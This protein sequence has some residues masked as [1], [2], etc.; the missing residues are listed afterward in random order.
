[1]LMESDCLP[2]CSR[3][4]ASVLGDSH[5]IRRA[6]WRPGLVSVLGRPVP[7]SECQHSDVRG[8]E[9]RWAYL[10]NSASLWVWSHG[11]PRVSAEVGALVLTPARCT[12]PGAGGD[13]SDGLPGNYSSSPSST[14]WGG[15]QVYLVNWLLV[16]WVQGPHLSGILQGFMMG[17]FGRADFS[18]KLCVFASEETEFLEKG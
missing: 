11:P 15:R 13:S 18:L 10:G 2:S 9:L 1:M 4:L 17:Y 7:P 16:T 14:G 12:F 6:G 3:D 8:L 5:G